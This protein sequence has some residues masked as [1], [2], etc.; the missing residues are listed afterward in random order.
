MTDYHHADYVGQLLGAGSTVAGRTSD[1]ETYQELTRIAEEAAQSEHA[2]TVLRALAVGFGLSAQQV[3]RA[4]GI[5][6]DIYVRTMLGAL[7]SVEKYR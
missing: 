1:Q 4:H 7:A 5:A 3:A 6:P 2:A